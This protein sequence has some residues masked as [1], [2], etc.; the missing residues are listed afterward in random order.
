MED[1]K[2]IFDDDYKIPIYE[3]VCYFFFRICDSFTYK[4]RGIKWFFQRGK[5]GY[6]DCDVWG[7]DS[8]LFEVII[9]G[10]EQLKNNHCGCPSDLFD[11]NKKGDECWKWVE[12][13]DKIINGFKAAERI[14]DYDYDIETGYGG[15]KKEFDEGIELFKKYFFGLWD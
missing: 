13:L 8:Y 1:L 5:K 7:F 3:R 15:L 14:I 9:G 12:V 6:S 10:L 11:N 4:I 2:D